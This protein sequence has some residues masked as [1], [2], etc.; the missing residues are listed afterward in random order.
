MMQVKWKVGSICLECL[1]RREREHKRGA[2]IRA[3]FRNR[4]GGR[5]MERKGCQQLLALQEN[6]K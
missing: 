5:E 6:R 3:G 2:G 4:E 1:E